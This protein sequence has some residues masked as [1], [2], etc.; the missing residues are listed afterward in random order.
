MATNRVVTA[1]EFKA[2]CLSM[3]D[4]VQQSGGVITVTKR[5][6]PV[7]VLGPAPK[8]GFKSPAGSWRGRMKI[9]G[10]I[11]DTSSMWEGSRLMGK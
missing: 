10:D 7:A 1:T 8:K 2:K 9:V 6:N 3:L 5:G 4:E 11:I